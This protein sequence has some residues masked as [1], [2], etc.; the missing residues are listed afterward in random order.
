MLT[1]DE[2]SGEVCR[3]RV[4]RAFRHTQDHLRIVQI[5][6]E[7]GGSQTIQ[8]TDE[9]PFWVEGTGWVEAAELAPG[10]RLVE[11]D[12]T[13]AR[14]VATRREAH[15]EG[16]PVF[17]IEV[18]GYHTYYVAAH[19]TRG[20]PVWVHNCNKT[21]ITKPYKRPSGAT[22]TAQRKSVQGKPCVDCGKKTPTMHAD[23][24]NPLVKEYYETGTIDKTHMR[25]IDA[26]QPQCPHCSNSQGGRLSKYSKDMKKKH[27]L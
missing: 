2:A 10:D 25:E 8:T 18:A 3:R 22:T 21:P 20:P 6:S 24:K 1:R 26:V 13:P 23:H 14:V 19:G 5:E 9:H 12:G 7:G 16:V 27:G 17:N 11:L 4:T 15:P